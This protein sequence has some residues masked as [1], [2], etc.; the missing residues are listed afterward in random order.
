VIEPKVV[1]TALHMMGMGG[2]IQYC[3]GGLY[4]REPKPK[5]LRRPTRNPLTPEQAATKMRAACK[6]RD[7]TKQ[8]ESCG[9]TGKDVSRVQWP[10]TK[11]YFGRPKIM[12]CPDCHQELDPTQ[13]DN[14]Q[15][16][17]KRGA[18]YW[19]PGDHSKYRSLCK[20]PRWVQVWVNV[21]HGDWAMFTW[22]RAR[23]AC[24]LDQLC[25]QTPR[26]PDRFWVHLLHSQANCVV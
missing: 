26:P 12:L 21:I 24:N 15:P 22:G 13:E 10:E 9:C 18:W 4:R 19:E 23:L 7:Q 3:E 2:T 25:F 11:Y 6:E 14:R 5:R 20:P 17:I 16:S 8:C 1:H